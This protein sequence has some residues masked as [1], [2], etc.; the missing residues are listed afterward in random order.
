[1]RRFAI[2]Q[3]RGDVADGNRL[4]C[5]DNINRDNFAAG[6]LN[7][8]SD[9]AKSTFVFVYFNAKNNIGTAAG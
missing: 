3:L 6:L 1:L 2:L 5:A 8:G 7:D 4:L 9:F